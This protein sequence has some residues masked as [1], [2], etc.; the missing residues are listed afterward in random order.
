MNTAA[1]LKERGKIYGDAVATHVRIAEVWSGIL[2]KPVTAHEVALCMIGLKLV[3]SQCS[4]D[5]LDSL[6]DTLGYAEI[7][8]Q[9]QG[10]SW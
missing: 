4:P 3:R 2:D 6:D 9:I 10:S 7:A 5:H 1:L 8:K